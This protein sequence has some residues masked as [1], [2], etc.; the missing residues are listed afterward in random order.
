MEGIM[1]LLR[2][3]IVLLSCIFSL[4]NVNAGKPTD[5]DGNFIGNG[6][7]SGPHFNLNIHGKKDGFKCPDPTYYEQVEVDVF[8]DPFD[9]IYGGELVKSCPDGYTCSPTNLQ[10]FG[11]VINL[12]RDG[13]DVQIYVESGRKGPKSSPN[14]VTL[15]VTDWCTKPFDSDAASFRLPANADGYAV[16]SRVTGRPVEDQYFEVFGRDLTVVEVEC[17]EGDTN[18]PNGGV[19]DLLLLGV[20]TDDGIF[21]KVGNEDGNFERVDDNDG[22]GGKG[23]KNATDVTGM[24]EFNGQVCYVYANDP[25]C[26]GDN[27][28]TTT[29]YCCPIDEYTLANNGAC[30][31]KE[32][33]DFWNSDLTTYDCGVHDGDP[34]GT[35]WI[36]QTFYCHDYTDENKW[37]FNVADFVEVLFG[38]R[39]NETYNIKLRFY[40][41]PLQD[42]KQKP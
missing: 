3:S 41:L 35:V 42:S 1:K 7:P 21:T 6:Y 34:V 13:S 9:E 5:S 12:P 28:C 19:Y 29:N 39:N 15:E 10:Y 8:D 2:T 26:S 20:V 17:Q 37:I 22:R 18:C 24:F 40:P 36:D 27:V 38:V 14:T 25:A 30:E 31:E 16:F 23:S 11:N 33:A 4:S 32:T